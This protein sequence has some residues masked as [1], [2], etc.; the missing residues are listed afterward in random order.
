MRTDL[1]SEKI[2]FLS[3][4]F[5]K[6]FIITMRPYLMF[7][8]GITGIAGISFGAGSFSTGYFLL[9]TSAFLSYG[10]GQVLTDCFQIDTDSLSSP[11]R[12][13]TKGIVSKNQFLSISI[14]GLTFCIMTF[15]FYNPINLILGAVSGLGLATYT[16]FKRR[17]WGGPFYNSWIVG[18]LF[19]MA[20]I[21][22]NGQ[23]SLGII[24]TLGTVFFGYANF[25]LSGYFKD[26]S[27]DS[28]TGYNT[29][30][31]V[32][33]RKISAAVSD[34]FALLALGFASLALI[35]LLK[36]GSSFSFVSILF[37][38]GGTAVLLLGQFRLHLVKTDDESYQ[39]ISYVVHS[40]I[41]LLSAIAAV[42][43][44]DWGLF[45]FIYYSFYLFILK[46]RPVKNQI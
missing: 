11:Y 36:T 10:F 40:Y 28:A 19:V 37:L 39:A 24:F 41:L 42:N 6:A 5:V 30:P 16:S 34:L 32:F 26:I 35:S 7:V 23:N 2:P 20:V 21:S 33:G 3:I 15:T 31:V 14:L 22:V 13:L 9:F 29:L 18:I 45:L 1:V 8:S 4:E 44:P 46:I 27:A 25:V 17:W 38:I 43:K 12:P